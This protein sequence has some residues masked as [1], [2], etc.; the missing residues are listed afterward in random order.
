M[1]WHLG[2]NFSMPKYRRY[3]LPGHP[4]FLTLVTHNRR[5][6]LAEDHCVEALLHSMHWVKTKYPFRHIAHA[7]LNDHVHWMLL[8]ES[9]TNL[10]GLVAALKRDA[11][12]RLKESGLSGPI[13]QKRFY[14]HIIRDEDDFARHLDYVHF[15][16]VKHGS[17]ESAGDHRWSSFSEWV[18]RGVYPTDWGSVEP[19]R[20]KD[21]E[22]Q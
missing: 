22:L 14:D 3:H 18:K 15:N 17:V 7:I 8:P 11:G 2:H 10:S 21:M 19:D 1:H 12:W 13:W 4:V 16:P 5:S 20:I 9:E 6:W